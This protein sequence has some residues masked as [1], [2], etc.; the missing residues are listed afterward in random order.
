[1]GQYL[2]HPP[3]GGNQTV[4]VNGRKYSTAP[5]TPINANDF[6]VPELEANGWLSIGLTGT[7]AQRPVNPPVKT[8]Y[9]DITLNLHIVWD[10][11]TWRNS[12]TGASV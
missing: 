2:V 4:T 8:V 6:D 5:G 7:T 3:A 12:I 10:G 11:K 9:A 1:M